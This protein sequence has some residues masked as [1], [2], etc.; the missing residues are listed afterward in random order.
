MEVVLFLA[1]VEDH[2][3]MWV[4]EGEGDGEDDALVPLP[5]L[6][7]PSFFARRPGMMGRRGKEEDGRE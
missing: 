3:R 5:S 2:H 1:S 4:G 6:F 7:S